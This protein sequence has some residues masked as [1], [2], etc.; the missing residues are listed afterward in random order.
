MGIMGI[1]G[2]GN[3]YDIFNTIQDTNAD[4]DHECIEVEKVFVYVECGLM[5][6]AIH[7][8]ISLLKLVVRVKMKSKASF[9]ESK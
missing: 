9:Q 5:F 8:N 2:V 3:N 4:I 7:F 1:S 6:Q